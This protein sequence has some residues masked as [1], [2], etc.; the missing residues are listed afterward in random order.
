V[1]GETLAE[2]WNGTR[3]SLQ[4]TPHDRGHEALVGVSCTSA[5]ACTAVGAGYDGVVAETWNG[6]SWSI[7]QAPSPAGFIWGGAGGV[8][9]TSA[10]ACTAVVS[11]FYR[12]VTEAW[13]GTSWSLQ[14]PPGPGG[15]HRILSDVSCV[16]AGGCT[17]VGKANGLTLAEARP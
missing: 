11:S 1:G 4:R 8:S 14:H 9:C 16:P 5:S 12:T 7:Q 2:R 10:S 13:N 17:T 15:S 6:T 3:W